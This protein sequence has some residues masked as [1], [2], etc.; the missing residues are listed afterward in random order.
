MR[1]SDWLLALAREAIDST[2]AGTSGSSHL[3][4]TI[5]FFNISLQ[6]VH[7]VHNITAR[8][9]CEAFWDVQYRLEWE[10]TVDQAPTVVEVC[11]DD[12]VLLYQ[13]C[14]LRVCH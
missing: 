12:T 11:G 7:T 4:A 9:M 14:V 10:I 6:A 1:R 5:D 3:I 8:E 13:V 2:R